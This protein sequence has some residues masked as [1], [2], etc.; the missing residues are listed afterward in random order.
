MCM[1]SLSIAANFAPNITASPSV[2][3]AEVGQEVEFTIRAIDPEGDAISYAM[4]SDVSGA[5]FDK[6]DDNCK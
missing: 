6:V 1:N 3:T 2:I 4:F 5:T